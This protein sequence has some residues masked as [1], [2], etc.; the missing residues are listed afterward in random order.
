MDCGRKTVETLCAGQTGYIENRR[1]TPTQLHGKF[2]PRPAKLKLRR[3]YGYLFYLTAFRQDCG[4]FYF[5]DVSLM[6]TGDSS[7][8]PR[9]RRIYSYAYADFISLNSHKQKGI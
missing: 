9:G 3:E 4:Y 2:L 8:K 1:Y 5:K 6:D 7:T